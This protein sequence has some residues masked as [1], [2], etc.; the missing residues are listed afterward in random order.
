MVR[1]DILHSCSVKL[2]CTTR[3]PVP[4]LSC[5]LLA[6]LGWIVAFLCLAAA[7]NPAS[8]ELSSVARLGERLFFDSR[9]S[10][11]GAVSCA[12][13]HRPERAFADH[14]ARAVGAAGREGVRN[15]PSLLDV[16]SQRSL[17][18]DGRQ[19]T[20]EAQAVEPL[21]N[22]FEHGLRDDEEV[23]RVLDQ[24][25]RY[26]DWFSSV[27]GQSEPVMTISRVG[28]ALA[29]YQ[30]TLRSGPAPID[31]F[32]AGDVSALSPRA[33]SGWAVFSG[34]AACTRCHTP[35]QRSASDGR[36]L[37]TDHAF[38]AIGIGQ[39]R[40]ARQL[41]KLVIAVA[42]NRSAGMPVDPLLL[43][44]PDVAAL[45]RFVV[46]LDLSDLGRFKT[47]GLRNVAL[48]APYMHDGSVPSLQDA[49]DHEIYYRG[50]EDGRPLV[51]TP[52]ERDDLVLFLEEGLTTRDFPRRVIDPQARSQ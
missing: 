41:P 35:D 26:A 3:L 5:V 14:R 6:A 2:T 29:A 10:Q 39:A 4:R 52:Q 44:N 19:S 34:P 20:L 40:I 28:K 12:A 49:V 50:R 25:A 13:C 30:R 32:L 17:F 45:G 38:H 16:G 43:G 42:R 23:L 18:W 31:R 7:A 36:P 21:I 48:T 22:L 51:L 15:A 11:D 33:R 8:D 24:D 1:F 46:T 47:P 9:L 37:F 27:F